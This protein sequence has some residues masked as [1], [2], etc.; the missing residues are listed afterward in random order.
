[1]RFTGNVISGKG[2]AGKA[3]PIQFKKFGR[4]EKLLL[5]GMKLATLNVSLNTC[6]AMYE[7]SYTYLMTKEIKW[8]TQYPAETFKL[9]PCTLAFKIGKKECTVNAVIYEPS[10]SPH[11]FSEG[12]TIEVIAPRIKVKGGDFVSIEL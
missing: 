7:K 2:S 10:H 12:R 8:S 11:R 3:L 5:S 1:M 9:Y 4:A 6:F